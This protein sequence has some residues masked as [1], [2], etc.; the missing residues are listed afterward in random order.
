MPLSDDATKLALAYM[1][2]N[3]IRGA[4]DKNNQNKNIPDELK[5]QT[6]IVD[7]IGILGKS[8]AP[9]SAPII[10]IAQ[11]ANQKTIDYYNKKKM[12]ENDSFNYNKGIYGSPKTNVV[13]I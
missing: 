8:I 2:F 6:N 13:G 10:D 7:V 4:I 12:Q 9:T 5:G 11:D 1:L 3:N